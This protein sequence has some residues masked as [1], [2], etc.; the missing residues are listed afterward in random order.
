ML[1]LFTLTGGYMLKIRAKLIIT[2]ICVVLL[3]VL[4]VS[5]PSIKTQYEHIK[6]SIQLTADANMSN[7]VS[8]IQSFMESPLQITKDTVP[9]ALHGN[10]NYE[11]T[12]KDLNSLIADN[13]ALFSMYYADEIPMS[14]GGNFYSSD[15]WIPETDYD[16]ESRIWFKVPKENRIPVVIDPYRDESSN[17]MV[18]TV[19]SPVYQDN[20]FKGVIGIDIKL[21]QVNTLVNKVKLSKKGFSF[22]LDKDGVYITNPDS[23]KMLNANFYKDYPVLAKYKNNTAEVQLDAGDGYY[24]AVRTIEN[25][26]GWTLVSVGYRKELFRELLININVIIVMSVISIQFSLAIASI[27]AHRIVK[28]ITKVDSAVNEIASG[29]ADLTQRINVDSNDEIGSL[30][31]GFNKFIEKLQNIISQIQ[32]SKTELTAVED[33]LVSSISE[34]SSSI[35]EIISNIESVGGQVGSQVSAVSQTSAAVTEIAENINSLELMIQNQSEGVSNA[36][37]AVE[38]MIGN[39]KAVNQS[40]EIMAQSFSQLEVTSRNGIDQ[41]R[42]VDEQISEV[43]KQS[44]SLQ[45]ANTAIADIA[46]QTNL[47]AM[48]AAIEAAHAGEYG[49]GFAVVADEIRKLSE[50][51]SDQSKK[52]SAELHKIVDTINH[53]V[54]ASAKST[55]SFGEVSNLIAE[56]DSLVKQI[57]SA[58]EEQQVGSRQILDSLSVMNNSTSEVKTASHEMKEGNE[59]ILKE[60]QNLQNTT[61]VIKQSM[62]EMSI[63]AKH[64]ND[65]S[66]TLSNISAQVSDAISKIGQQIDLF[67]A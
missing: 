60:I 12:P 47:L 17:A 16:K 35:T 42:F 37:S 3:A 36:S 31:K 51:S 29:N 2:Y 8:Y 40:V 54:E 33:N 26:N 19:A 22:L 67:K 53:V 28:P 44:K 4:C 38:E 66:S 41:Q 65:T 7:A 56:T 30:E 10:L 11:Q 15:G 63:G 48:N 18:T 55:E 43:S 62:N 50:T 49:K 61:L 23:K 20:E 45:D 21:E 58:M 46:S 13:S 6:E 59:M 57:N 64:M 25:T 14:Q 34:A 9:Y 24:F 5:I 39:I 52:I 27:F 32:G 1:H